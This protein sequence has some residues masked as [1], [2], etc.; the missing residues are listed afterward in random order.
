MQLA[1]MRGSKHCLIREALCS[2]HLI[3]WAR[4][5]IRALLIISLV[6]T[7]VH[8]MLE[9]AVLDTLTGRDER[10]RAGSRRKGSWDIGDLRAS[11]DI[12]PSW[13]VWLE[14]LYVIQ[15]EAGR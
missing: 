10:L 13:L 7:I 4:L 6:S 14:L 8:G 5:S 2:L 1:E 11:S 3:L 15:V 12:Y 9:L